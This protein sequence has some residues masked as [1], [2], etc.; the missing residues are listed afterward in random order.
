M[1]RI[2]EFSGTHRAV[3]RAHG[4]ELRAGVRRELEQRLERC[5]RA[6]A[7]V[8]RE[9]AGGEI[10]ALAGEHL[11]HVRRFSAGLYQE[12]LGIAEGAGVPV[13]DAL[14]VSGYTDVV[15]AVRSAAGGAAGGNRG[16]VGCTAFH[17]SAEACAAGRPLLGQ[18]WD[19]FTWGRTDSY[20]RL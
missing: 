19:M 12:L 10:R 15:D 5:R 2:R 1:L 17:A 18:T 20:N 4:E 6:S 8:G 11:P 7:Q 16:D 3:G 13:G 14:L 9:L